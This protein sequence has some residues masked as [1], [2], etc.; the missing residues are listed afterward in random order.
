M[1]KRTQER[2]RATRSQWVPTGIARTGPDEVAPKPPSKSGDTDEWLAIPRPRT[3]G[4]RGHGGPVNREGDAA[5]VDAE[6]PRRPLKR[7]RL[8]KRATARERWLIGRLR[9][10]KQRVEEQEE[11][12]D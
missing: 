11:E 8:P 3:L 5:E 9:R 2:K 6:R 4:A 10:A 1:A 12:I 7:R